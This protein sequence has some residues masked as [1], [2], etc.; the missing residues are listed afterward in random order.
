GTAARTGLLPHVSC[1]VGRVEEAVGWAVGGRTDPAVQGTVWFP[2]T[3]PE[4]TGWLAEDVH[5]L[6][7]TE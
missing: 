1:E 2:Y 7:G 5:G 4:K 6:S 3:V